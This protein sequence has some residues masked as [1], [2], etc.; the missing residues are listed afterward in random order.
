MTHTRIMD[1]MLLKNMNAVT[2]IVVYEIA[3]FLYV[4]NN[5]FLANIANFD[6][7]IN[8]ETQTAEPLRGCYT[9]LNDTIN[10][11]GERCG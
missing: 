5:I 9:Q 7:L 4:K 1:F 3:F 10:T 6:C 8:A 11:G 2:D